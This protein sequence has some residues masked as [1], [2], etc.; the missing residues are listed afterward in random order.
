VPTNEASAPPTPGPDPRLRRIEDLLREAL[1]R[2]DP[3]DA[4]IGAVCADLLAF[5]YRLKQAMD[6]K[7]AAGQTPKGPRAANAELEAY[8][9]VLRQLDRLVQLQRQRP[10]AAGAGPGAA[11]D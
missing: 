7:A 3:L 4:S 9:K 11:G 6:A 5:A 8:L 1:A 2:P 10:R